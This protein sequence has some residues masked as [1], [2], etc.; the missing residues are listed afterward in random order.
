MI[1][2]TASS[3]P[4]PSALLV[5][6]KSM[7]LICT[8]SCRPRSDF[9]NSFRSILHLTGSHLRRKRSTLTLTLPDASL[10]CVRLA[11]FRIE[12]VGLRFIVHNPLIR[13][14]RILTLTSKPV[15]GYKHYKLSS[16]TQR[17]DLVPG[18]L[19]HLRYSARS[20]VLYVYPSDLISITIQV[21]H[22]KF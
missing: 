1:P 20:S 16:L 5:S 9:L 12:L 2:L 7:R 6:G 8:R 18:R 3:A 22:I 19:A 13:V 4:E 21:P 14:E 11:R 17:Q 15:E 10:H